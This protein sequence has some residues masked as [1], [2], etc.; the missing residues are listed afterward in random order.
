MEGA[1]IN[2]SCILTIFEQ[3]KWQ[4][5]GRNINQSSVDSG[6]AATANLTEDNFKYSIHEAILESGYVQ[7]SLFIPRSNKFIH[8]GLYRCNTLYN[9]GIFVTI[10]DGRWHTQ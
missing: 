2:I 8:M 5:N 7:S 9:D 4:L 3:V 1:P 10:I 6:F